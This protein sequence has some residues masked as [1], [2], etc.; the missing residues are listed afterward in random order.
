M[1][2]RVKEVYDVSGLETAI[3]NQGWMPIDNIVVWRHPS[4]GDRYVVVEGNTRT[5]A[6][7]DF[8]LRLQTEKKKLERLRG[9]RKSYSKHDVEEQ[10]KLVE[11][12][13]RIIADTETLSVLP[14]A[15]KDIKELR[16]KLPRVLA[17]RHI[18]GAKVWGNY[19]EDLW[20]LRRYE[21]LFEHDYPRESLALKAG[22]LDQIAHEASLTGVATKRKIVAAS[23]FSHFK[24]HFEDDLPDGES[25]EASDYYLFENIVKKP[26]LREQF[27]L[28][29]DSLHIP[30]ELEKVLF[31]W[32][33]KL[34]RGKTADENK[35]VFYRHE[36]VLVWDQMKRY[37]EDH[38]TSFARRFDVTDAE[39]APP[40]R[41]V[42]AEWLGH[43]ASQQPVD[44]IE[45]L[46]Q[47]LERL[48]VKALAG[49]G[50]FLRKQL[51]LLHERSGKVLKAIQ[52]LHSA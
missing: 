49:E 17:V 4:F 34:P 10:E 1:V 38:K 45:Q 46:L 6:L 5:V 48:N 15:A 39:S 8:R 16:Q 35:N 9:G 26:W 42:E 36:N 19:A 51:E 33:F 2:E 41:K 20:L 22:P 44:V 18:T 40:M 21:T 43:K 14:L 25:L 30:P 29:A 11:R 28:G 50:G 7:R 27:G 37:D 52:A 47:Q 23:C 3:E 32:V 31:Q 24:A 13:E 12:L